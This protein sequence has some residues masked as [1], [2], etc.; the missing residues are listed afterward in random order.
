[1][2]SNPSAPREQSPGAAASTDPGRGL[3]RY[4]LALATCTALLVF[5]GGLVTSTDAG[6]SVPDWPL[7]YGQV[8]PP[9]VGNVRFEHGH[10]MVATFVGMLSIGMVVFLWKREPRRWVRRLGWAALGVVVLQGVL[11]GMTVLFLLPTS[12]SVAHACL[13]QTF[14]C[15]VVSLALFTSSR[16]RSE[17]APAPAAASGVPL[18][19]MATITTTAIYLQL[20]LGALMRHTDSG[21]AIPDFPLAFGRLVPPL[22]DP[23]V[24]VHF[25]HRVGA[26]VVAS[27]VAAAATQVLRQHRRERYLA[28]PAILLVALLLVQVALGATTVWTHKAVVPTTLHVLTGALVLATSLVLTLRSW[29]LI[30]VPQRSTAFAP[31]P[32]GRVAT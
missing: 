20:L 32:A 11:G 15:I 17:A 1:M 10:R 12:I 22:G 7:S 26:L 2:T 23:K 16:W 3:Y 29:R 21:L 13:A 27:S 5:A 14:F 8:M 28:R 4:A 24:A 9:M 19:T 18:R 31:I 30:A 6:L 25:A